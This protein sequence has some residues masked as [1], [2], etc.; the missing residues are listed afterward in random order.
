MALEITHDL[1]A[2]PRIST[3]RLTDIER[4]EEAVGRSRVVD[5]REV[6]RNVSRELDCWIVEIIGSQI[7]RRSKV[8]CFER[9]LP[10]LGAEQLLGSLDADLAPR[11]D[12]EITGGAVGYGN[13]LAVCQGHREV[14]HPGF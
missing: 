6:A 10:I 7:D 13:I 12:E 3:E 9:R 4:V 1:G 2:L 11:G 5:R 8:S 14:G